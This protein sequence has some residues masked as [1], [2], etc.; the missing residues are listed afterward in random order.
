M[1]Q[2]RKNLLSFGFV[3]EY[4]NEQNIELLPSDI[5]E[6]LILWLSFVDRVDLYLSHNAIQ[7][8]TIMDNKFGECEQ[9]RKS[10]EWE[11]QATAIFHHI[12]EKG[13]KQS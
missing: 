9:I 4:C 12:V 7:I 13:D 6:L 5:I 11:S 10:K 1:D 2:A 8:E 3:R